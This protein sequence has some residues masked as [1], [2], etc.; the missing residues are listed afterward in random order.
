MAARRSKT[1]RYRGLE[2]Y[3]ERGMITVID[4]D[5]AA[6]SEADPHDCVKRIPPGKFMQSAI[7]VHMST[8]EQFPDQLAQSRRLLDDAKIVC[9]LAKA[10][11]DPTEPGVLEHFARHRRRSSALILPGEVHSLLG[12]VGGERFKVDLSKP[13]K[14]M[15]T[16]GATTR[17]D[18]SIDMSNP[19][20]I[21]PKRA[22]L[23]RKARAAGRQP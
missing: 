1:Y 11:G 20:A 23:M 15:L 7:A 8:A 21:T 12:P 16:G 9:K 13:R 18:L 19:S 6:D 4:A 2:F 14:D 10:Q 17:P 3:A 5:T 22:A